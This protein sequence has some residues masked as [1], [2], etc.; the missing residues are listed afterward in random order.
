MKIKH[1][2]LGTILAAFVGLSVSAMFSWQNHETVEQVRGEQS[3]NTTKPNSAAVWKEV[4]STPDQM[5]VGV[6]AIVLAEAISVVPSRVARSENSE[7]ELPFELVTF[8]VSNL[9]KGAKSEEL[10]YV[11][12]AG[13]LDSNGQAINLDLDGG[14]F[15]IGKSYLLFLKQQEEGPYF[16]QVNDQGRYDVVGDKLKAVG[17]DETDKVKDSFKN[18]TV[19]EGL[20]MVKEKFEKLKSEGK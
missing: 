2:L 5:I 3:C 8:R 18:K 16:Y 6:D 10:V 14:N 13:G 7:D 4:Y 12:R 19:G 11:E 20:R 9:I 17:N 15:E 1:F